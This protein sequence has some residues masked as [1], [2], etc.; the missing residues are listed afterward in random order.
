LKSFA[1]RVAG[2]R[3]PGLAEQCHLSLL[4][5]NDH[6]RITSVLILS[7][8]YGLE[9][10]KRCRPRNVTRPTLTASLKIPVALRLPQASNAALIKSP[11][12]NRLLF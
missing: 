12:I 3:T 2:Q 10:R 1:S 8:G 9:I 4:D 5:T 6:L 7:C 11:K